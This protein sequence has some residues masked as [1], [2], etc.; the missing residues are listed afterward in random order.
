MRL[1]GFLRNVIQ[2]LF[3]ILKEKSIGFALLTPEEPPRVMRSPER[4]IVGS[5]TLVISGN[6]E[7]RTGETYLENFED[8]LVRLLSG[9]SVESLS[10]SYIEH[11]EVGVPWE[12]LELRIPWLKTWTPILEYFVGL[13]SKWIVRVQPFALLRPKVTILKIPGEYSRNSFEIAGSLLRM[14]SARRLWGR[15]E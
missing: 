6:W 12:F 7:G 11:I 10:Y 4:S 8:T 1:D 5:R 13:S 3:T 9:E 14:L 2:D 15:G